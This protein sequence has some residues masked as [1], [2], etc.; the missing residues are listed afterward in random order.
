MELSTFLAV[1]P[2][3][4]LRRLVLLFATLTG[5]FAGQAAVDAYL[6]VEGVK[7]EATDSSHTDWIQIL[8][9]SQ[10]TGSP[11]ATTGRP[12]FS[13][14]CF[15]KFADRS[16]PVLEQS[17]AKGRVFPSATLELIT[18]D[19]NRARFYQIV[20]SNVVIVSVSASGS[21]ADLRP[22]ESVCLG[23]SQINWT[24]TEFDATG[25]PKNNIKAWW[26]LALN[27][28]GGNVNPVL[29]V[30]GTQ[31][32]GNSLQLSWPALAGRTYQ[33][34]GGGLVTGPYQVVQSIPSAQD[35]PMSQTLPMSGGARFFILQE[36]P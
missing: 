29:R 8:S 35:G 26:D 19:A 2:V 15:Q 3:S 14:L 32:G 22:L 12:S 21:T 36:A 17:C 16:S 20:L 23:F 10:G 30:T 1:P 24:Y 7:G 27:I 9:F 13:D 33:I 18:A 11:L 31:V 5:A 4:G 28:G 6:K 34:L 25:L